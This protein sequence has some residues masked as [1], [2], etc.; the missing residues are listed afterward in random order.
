MIKGGFMNERL[1][2]VVNE[3]SHI[4][5]VFPVTVDHQDVSQ[6]D[7]EQE[8]LKAAAAA[9]IVPHSDLEKLR[10][11]PHISRGGP[12]APFGDA[13]QIKCEQ[14]N[15]LEQRIRERAY[16]LWLE[17][18]CAGNRA[19]DYWYRASEIEGASVGY[20]VGPHCL[21]SQGTECASSCL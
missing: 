20:S 2:D 8:A 1:M 15:R 13:L 7:L 19:D 6:A 9:E 21:E 3:N 14:Q 17:A 10:A 5:H 4:L 16:F 12:L 18:D 11:K